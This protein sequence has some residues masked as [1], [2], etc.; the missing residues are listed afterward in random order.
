MAVFIQAYTLGRVV[1]DISSHKVDQQAWVD[2]VQK[3]VVSVMFD[4]E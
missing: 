1:D 4:N 3:V 2:L